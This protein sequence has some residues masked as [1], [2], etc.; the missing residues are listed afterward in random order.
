MG[1]ERELNPIT[2]VIIVA[3]KNKCPNGFA[4]IT[5]TYDEQGDAD[6]WKESSFSFFSRPVRYLAISREAPPNTVGVHVV[7]DLCVVRESDPIP[8]GFI[9]ID[10]TADSKEK[11]LRKKYLCVRTVARDAVVDA[12][13]DIIV[14]SKQRK[15]P[16]NYSSAGEIDG[17]TICFK[18]IVI[19]SSFGV[20]IPRSQSSSGNIGIYPSMNNEFRNS[21]PSLADKVSSAASGMKALTI[22]SGVTRRG[23]ED[24]PFKLNPLIESAIFKN[25]ISSLPEIKPC[26][27]ETVEREYDYQFHVERATL[28]TS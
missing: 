28:S 4:P 16:K 5:K 1:D 25:Q 10:Y 3:D 11:S 21:A 9:A 18:H 12:V 14:L 27:R 6:L 13:G 17:T 15:P 2:A 24:V 7:T 20:V 26:D 8:L 19:P 23:I 22:K